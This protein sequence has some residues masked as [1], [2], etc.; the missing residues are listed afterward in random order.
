MNDKKTDL[1]VNVSVGKGLLSQVEGILDEPQSTDVAGKNRKPVAMPKPAPAK[2]PSPQPSAKSSTEKPV[3]K[4]EAVRKPERVSVPEV[5]LGASKEDEEYFPEP[6]ERA[7]GYRGND[8]V[9]PELE[10][11]HEPTP[12]TKEETCAQVPPAPRKSPVNFAIAS[13]A[14]LA[15]MGSVYLQLYPI[16]VNDMSLEVAELRA[17]VS[18][19]SAANLALS[20]EV[21]EQVSTIDELSNVDVGVDA[22]ISSVESAIVEKYDQKISDG[23]LASEKAVRLANQALE[24]ASNAESSSLQ[25]SEHAELARLEL[26]VLINNAREDILQMTGAVIET[27]EAKIAKTYV[28][29]NEMAEALA[30]AGTNTSKALTDHLEKVVVGVNDESRKRMDALVNKLG[31]LIA[32]VKAEVSLNTKAANQNKS[33][34]AE[35]QS[36]VSDIRDINYRLHKLEGN[37]DVE[38]LE[39]LSN[40]LNSLLNSIQHVINQ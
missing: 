38:E 3:T 9:Q 32:G 5:E 21:A 22:I 12:K 39:A 23:V 1:T 10:E 25:A 2:R 17:E 7:L 37:V 14:L 28:N 24:S 6:L 30:L 40:R 16:G 34:L 11:Q 33:L 15:S 36:S 31:T 29:D 18:S 20:S 26:E 19:L 27:A 8:S 4:Q 35:L 13:L